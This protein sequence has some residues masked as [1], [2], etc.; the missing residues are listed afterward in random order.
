MARR[1]LLKPSGATPGQ[2]G[3]GLM[4][5]QVTVNSK[6]Q[7]TSI[8]ET[9]ITAQAIVD[10]K[11]SV[12][13]AT[14]TA[15]TLASDFE[16][17]DTIDGVTLATG[18][19]ILIKDQATGSQ[20]GIYVVAASGAPS[21]ATDF[22]ADAEVTAGCVI[23][24][25]EGTANGNTLFVLTTNDPI[26]VGS[27]TLTFMLLSVQSVGI[28]DFRASVR[29]AT[30]TAGTLATSFENGDT[31]DGVVLATSDRILIKN[32][33]APAENGIYTVN[34]SGAPTRA[35]DFDADAE[36]EPGCVI[37]VTAGTVNANTL[38]MLT[39]EAPITLGSTGLT[40]SG[41]AGT[42]PDHNHTGTGDGG[43]LDSP[44]I[45]GYAEF[46]EESAPGSASSGFVRLYAKSDGLLY[47]KDDA[48]TETQVSG[49]GGGSA[50][51]CD[52]EVADFTWVNQGDATATDETDIFVGAIQVPGIVMVAPANSGP[53]FRE[54]VKTAPT[55]PYTITIG[56]LPL[57]LSQ[58]FVYPGFIWRQSSDGKLIIVGTRANG[59]AYHTHISKWNSET[60][61]SGVYNDTQWHMP[62]A[63]IRWF[64]LVDDNTNRKVRVSSDGRTWSQLHSVG[65]TDF[66][67]AN[68]VG[69]TIG[70]Q[71][72]NFDAALSLVHWVE[73]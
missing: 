67:T 64:Q 28:R 7:I 26:T 71:N 27:T 10:F 9:A 55:P 41:L 25:A 49:G 16:N 73:T 8:V 59:A 31:I 19:R 52:V 70:Q 54:L 42:F 24:V 47:S 43:D 20:N 3:T 30:V 12:R 61:F 69:I 68:Q 34:A 18:D 5:P 17:G 32:Q 22:D 62:V 44:V 46:A 11:N 48:G 1:Y 14:T 65:R 37:P 36:A 56:F 38:W 63:M 13:V 39:T 21:R 23:P 6:G 45:D 58:D 72:G 15:G 53:Q 35:T 33:A 57:H 40:F 4:V 66:L 50:L 29:V 2:Y 60:S 51:V